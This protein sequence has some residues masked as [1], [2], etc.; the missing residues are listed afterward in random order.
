MQADAL[1]HP[2]GLGG[3]LYDLAYGSKRKPAP[4]SVADEQSLIQLPADLPVAYQTAVSLGVLAGRFSHAIPLRHGGPWFHGG[5][6]LAGQPTLLEGLC[7]PC[8]PRQFGRTHS[9]FRK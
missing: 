7:P 5:Q 3:L 8:L 9:P 4:A 1:C 6:R 2:S